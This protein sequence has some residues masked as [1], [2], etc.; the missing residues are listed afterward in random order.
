MVSS[1]VH[2]IV[3]KNLALNDLCLLPAILG[4][5]TGILVA[6]ICGPGAEVRE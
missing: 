4:S 3:N 1:S 5:C 6:I 2:T